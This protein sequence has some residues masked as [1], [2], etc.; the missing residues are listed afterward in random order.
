M[1]QRHHVSHDV[2]NRRLFVLHTTSV[3]RLLHTLQ[4]PLPVKFRAA[5]HASLHQSILMGP[6]DDM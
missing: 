5:K 3:L 4:H 6:W 1:P 2:N